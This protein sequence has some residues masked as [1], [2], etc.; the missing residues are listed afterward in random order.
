MGNHMVR[1]MVPMQVIT[2]IL[3]TLSILNVIIANR[4]IPLASMVEI[5]ITNPTGT[6]ITI[7][8]NTMDS[9]HHRHRHREMFF[10]VIL[11]IQHHRSRD[12]RPSVNILLRVSTGEKGWGRRSLIS[13]PV[14]LLPEEERIDPIETT[15]I[16][17]LPQH[18]DL[19]LV[20]GLDKVLGKAQDRDKDKHKHKDQG[21]DR[22]DQYQTN[23]LDGGEGG[24]TV[25]LDGAFPQVSEYRTLLPL[26]NM[27]TEVVAR[28][29][30]PHVK[31]IILY[32]LLK[33]YSLQQLGLDGAM[34]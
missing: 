34:V 15:L 4:H 14:I 1:L 11:F 32:N 30:K 7:A 13:L 16:L 33:H 27:D 29:Q 12:I 28:V 25:I 20:L 9:H 8:H 21:L 3:L 18:L 23:K 31:V 24:V 17:Q 22:E 19:D 10:Q 26:W 2:S 6:V 5:L